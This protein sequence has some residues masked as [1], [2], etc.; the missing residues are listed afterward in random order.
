M[1][2]V[3]GSISITIL[4]PDMKKFALHWFFSLIGE[5]YRSIQG[6]QLVHN[7]WNKAFCKYAASWIADSS[8]R[9]WDKLLIKIG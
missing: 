7:A 2:D 9:T 8:I 1:V 5:A 4:F 6:T 3:L